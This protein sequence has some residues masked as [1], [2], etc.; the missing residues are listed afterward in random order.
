M[1]N[2]NEVIIEIL[3]E[4]QKNPNENPID[5]VRRRYLRKISE[6]TGRNTIAYYSAFMITNN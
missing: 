3:Q 4:Q 5:S 6:I 2:W 1:P